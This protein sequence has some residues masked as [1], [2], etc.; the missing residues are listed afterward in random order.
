VSEELRLE[1]ALDLIV[2]PP[3][4]KNVT[5]DGTP[6]SLARNGGNTYMFS[7]LTD[8]IRHKKTN[9]NHEWTIG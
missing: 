4:Y 3:C 7:S 9:I 2:I 5:N 6:E 1:T 8:D